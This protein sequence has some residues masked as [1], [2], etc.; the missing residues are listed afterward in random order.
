MYEK[1][2]N[3]TIIYI[4]ILLHLHL[5]IFFSAFYFD[6]LSFYIT[7]ARHKDTKLI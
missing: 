4:K 2:T 6:V 3:A 7:F 1:K 5:Y